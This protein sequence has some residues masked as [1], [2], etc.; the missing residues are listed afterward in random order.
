MSSVTAGGVLSIWNVRV[1][2]ARLPARSVAIAVTVSGPSTPPV[3]ARVSIVAV[4][5]SLVGSPSVS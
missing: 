1:D 4:A 2:V 3:A 5:K